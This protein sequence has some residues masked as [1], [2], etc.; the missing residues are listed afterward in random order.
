M[1]RLEVLQALRK[2]IIA[3]NSQKPFQEILIP[4]DDDI[5]QSDPI[6][7]HWAFLQWE[8]DEEIRYL[9]KQIDKAKDGGK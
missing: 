4:D 2:A 7:K 3:I 1:T 5:E 6:C 9:L 8:I